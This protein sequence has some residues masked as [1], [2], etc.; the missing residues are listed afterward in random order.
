VSDQVKAEQKTEQ[1]GLFQMPAARPIVDSPHSDRLSA[2]E[3]SK[4]GKHLSKP[5]PLKHRQVSAKTCS[6]ILKRQSK[7][8][9]DYLICSKCAQL[10]S[11]SLVEAKGFNLPSSQPPAHP[12][13][14]RRPT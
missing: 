1:M 11:R 13:R 9:N 8:P 4:S 7:N 3:P 12:G 10:V 2:R 5:R 6:G 14:K